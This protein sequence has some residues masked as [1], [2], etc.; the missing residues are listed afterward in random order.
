MWS[1][2]R[3][4]QKNKKRDRNKALYGKRLNVKKVI[5]TKSAGFQ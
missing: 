2:E 5:T 1:L 4:N 3:T